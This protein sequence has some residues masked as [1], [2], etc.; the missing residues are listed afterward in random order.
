VALLSVYILEPQFQGQTKDR[1][2]NPE[3][4]AQVD[5]AVRPALEKWLNENPTLAAP[6]VGRIVLAARAREASRAAARE[7]IRKTAVSHRMNLPGKLA[8][9]SSTD[10]AV[11]ELF[12]VEGDSAGGSAKQGRDRETQA[13]LPLRGKVLNAEQANSAKV[14]GN[15]ELSDIVSALGCGIG[16]QFDES[17]LRYGK[18]FLLMD[19]DADGHHI[20]TLLLTFFWRHLPKLIQS[21]HV[22]LA[23]PPLYRIDA[24][25]STYWALDEAERD[26]ILAKLPKNVKPDI[27]RF[28]GLGEMM[29]AQLRETT[30][31]PA[32]R[33][34]LKVTVPSVLEAEKVLGEL[35]GKDPS[36]RYRFITE[37]AK[38]ADSLDV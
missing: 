14:T 1:L 31:D 27:M 22:Y 5:G 28:K 34:A 36:A 3:L 2:N 9:C 13:I 18:V 7:V 16:A 11:S 20:S 32:R 25:Q 4:A 33:R 26:A 21:G 35:M 17:K 10:P 37:R 12:I 23:Q 15:R 29:P 38:E 6:I 8:D 24:A 19:A 30:L